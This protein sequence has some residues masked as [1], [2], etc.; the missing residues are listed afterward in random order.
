VFDCDAS[1]FEPISPL[2]DTEDFPESGAG[3]RE[4]A[5]RSG[6]LNP[7][8]RR[9]LN[10]RQVPGS[11]S[12]AAK[13]SFVGEGRQRPLA[14]WGQFGT[15]KTWGLSDRYPTVHTRH[16]CRQG[17]LVTNTPS[18]TE[19]ERKVAKALSLAGERNQ[20]IHVLINVGRNPSTNFGRL[21]GVKEWEIEPATDDEVSKFRFEK[22]LVDL[23]TG[24]S[25]FADERLVRAREAMLLAVQTFNNPLLH[26]K[27]ELFAVLSNIAWTYL[28]HEFY[29]RKGTTVVNEAGYALLLSQMLERE[30]CPLAEDVRKNISAVKV[31]RDEVEHTLLHSL[32]RTFY[33]LFQANCLNFENALIKLY[34]ERVALGESLTYALQFSKLTMEQ[35]SIVQKYDLNQEIEAIN[36][37]ID[38]SLGITG[39]EGISYKFK[40]N[41]SLEKSTKGDANFVFTTTNPEGT[42]HQ[43]LVDKVASDELWPHKPGKVVAILRAKTGKPFSTNQHTLAWKKFGVRPKGGSPKPN[44]CNKK[45]C[46][47]HSAHGDYTYS[48]AWVELLATVVSDD[49][50]YKA[51]QEFNPA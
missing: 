31:V 32:G 30:D 28:L 11:D 40:V 25:P 10:G 42:A 45:Y 29:V 9:R 12:G 22:S 46:T 1:E 47:Y 13:G 24:L 21:S 20:D 27:P 8:D 16:R 23:R 18:L 5:D 7:Q 34:G 41:F 14:Q 35:L 37:K 38:Q 43:V 50:Q 33:P 26:F 44:S 49:E 4:A 39:K 2:P 48:D 3:L 19:L 17:I 51:L 15:K 36:E 6:P